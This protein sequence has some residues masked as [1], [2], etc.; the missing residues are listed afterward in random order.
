MEYADIVAALVGVF[1]V[2]WIADMLT[3]RRGLFAASLVSAT[4]AACGWFLAV[5]VFGAA[6]M[7]DFL[8]TAW[9]AG[10]A[11]LA[12]VAFYLFRNTR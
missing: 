2:A 9:A 3:G 11:I 12:L 6:T 4:G 10:G 1:A 5:R 7:D 8:W